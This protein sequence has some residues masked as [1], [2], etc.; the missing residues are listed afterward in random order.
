MRDRGTK[1]EKETE[2][3]RNIVT[4][5]QRAKGREIAIHRGRQKQRDRETERDVWRYVE[6]D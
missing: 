5:E 4:K 2:R 6:K 3:R 1:R